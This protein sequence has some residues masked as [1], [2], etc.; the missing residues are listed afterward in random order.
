M[1]F[2]T[3]RGRQI[4]LPT[5]D[6]F[7]L[8][9]SIWKADHNY[10]AYSILRMCE[11]IDNLP[12]LVSFVS[13]FIAIHLNS[14]KLWIVPTC[15]AA[16]SFVG[17]LFLL[18]SGFVGLNIG[19]PL[20]LP[21]LRLWNRIPELSRLA[22]PPIIIAVVSHGTDSILWLVGLLL[23]SIASLTVLTISARIT[24]RRTGSL[25]AQAERC[26]LIA[27]EWCATKARLDFQSLM[28]KLCTRDA[29]DAQIAEECLSDYANKHPQYVKIPNARTLHAIRQLES[30]EGMHRAQTADE[31]FEETDR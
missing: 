28:L 21:I 12:Q 14:D 11:A 8:M 9:G 24:Y 26:F 25:L 23:G 2:R 5:E 18:G 22:G 15:M 10:D 27:C 19:F 31:M 29:N 20:L 6:G 4:D 13:G 30:R 17:A 1:G 7:V 3:P 16:G